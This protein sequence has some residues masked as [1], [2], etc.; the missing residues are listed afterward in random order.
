MGSIAQAYSFVA[1]AIPSAANWNSNWTTVLALVNGQIDKANVDSSGTDGIVT[2]DE[3]QTIS[4]AK[5]MTG[6]LT[7]GV[8]GTGVD[9]TFYGDTVGQYLKWDQSA[10]ELVLAG[11][12]KL[13]FHDAAGGENII[14]TSNGHLEI[15]AGTTLDITAPTVDLNSST[16]FNIDTA[17]YDLNASGD[18][19]LTST[20]DAA[21]AIYLRA[22]AGTSET[23]KIHADQGTSVTEGASSVQLLSDAGG[24]ELKS[25]ANLA[26]S[27]KLIADGGT[28]ETI[29]IQADQGTGAG[30]ITLVSDAG[31]IDVD[32]V[33]ISLDASAASNLT[34]SSGALTITSA[35]AATW[36]TAA[37]ALTITSAAAAT[38]S[39][40]AGN[41]TITSA[42]VL[43]ANGTTGVAIQEGGADIITISNARAIE[44]DNT[45]SIDLDAS[46]AI[47]MNS[48]GGTLSIGSDNVDQVVN[49][50]TAGTRTLNIGIN[51]GTD[52]T[53]IVS[54]GNI[55]N[56]GTLTV[57]VNDTG[58]DVKF[59][60]ATDGN[61][62]LWDES[63]D[64]LIVVGNVGINDTSPEARLKIVADTDGEYALNV[65]QQ[66]TG[67][68]GGILLNSAG[69]N[70]GLFVS[71]NAVLAAQDHALTVYTNSIQVNSALAK[72]HQDH[73]SSTS[74][75]MFI[76]NDGTGGAILIHQD[77]VSAGGKQ[78]LSILSEVA[79]TNAQLVRLQL[80][81]ASSTQPVM[82][83]DNVG[84]AVTLKVVPQHASAPLGIHVDMGAASPD[85]NTAYFFRG[86]DSTTNRIYIYSD[87]D[88]LN[89][90]GTYGTISDEKLK[91]DIEPAHSY[92]EE[93]KALAYKKFRHICDVEKSADAPY[94]IGLV[95]QDVEEIF[96]A[97][98][99][100]LPDVEEGVGD[101]EVLTG[102]TTKAIKSSIIDGV[103]NSIVL[104][105]A[106]KR[107]E[108]LE[109]KLKVA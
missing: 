25:T 26:K 75:V 47:T 91:R 15:N 67:N 98:V 60:G 99:I 51:D 104:Q 89:H 72:F 93:F 80:T 74:D 88:I 36:S 71:Q 42:G 97:L 102:T 45:A 44:T 39:T 108:I 54:K 58:H 38:W 109:A 17:A 92:W 5:I 10:D 57:G 85:D 23:I 86:E 64:N 22:N 105:E 1:G 31:G 34:T 53:T 76:D 61:Y 101:E 96:P 49:L 7:T 35:A 52:I 69:T 66:A 82:R 70:H 41:L 107:I 9:V 95:A 83:M 3:A 78:V 84:S 24:V 65:D 29:Y 73:L 12:T 68:G 27:I 4:G 20:N 2:M 81:H 59:F 32:A 14:A 50:A 48:S 16:E 55:T 33:G 106:M 43:T 8:S 63:E 46:G 90:D 94:R 40:A 28:S 6:T 62:M 103:I 100:E 18:I 19:E 77:G 21:D 11:D 13:S 30:S 56:T 79:Q 37:G 87:G